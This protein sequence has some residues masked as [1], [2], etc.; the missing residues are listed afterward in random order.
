MLVMA[1]EHEVEINKV[2]EA[3]DI[4]REVQSYKFL[5]ITFLLKDVLGSVTKLNKIIKFP[6][7]TINI[8]VMT[9]TL[10]R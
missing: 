6:T 2:P 5:A 10:S 7:E 9:D 4:L 8:C 3:K 1:L